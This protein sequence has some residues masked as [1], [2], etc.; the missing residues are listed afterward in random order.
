MILVDS[1]ILIDW[2]KAGLNPVDQLRSQLKS[3][4]VLTCEIIRFEVL[5]GCRNNPKAYRNMEKLFATMIMVSFDA[6]VW[7]R[8]LEIAAQVDGIGKPMPTTDI[9][10]AAGAL[11]RDAE[12]I[13]RDQH[14]AAV[15]GLRLRSEMPNADSL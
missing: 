9:L 2:M 13:T 11:S 4:D 3:D 5:R 14:F 6:P 15:S 12:L 10:I 8:A 1:C 7:R